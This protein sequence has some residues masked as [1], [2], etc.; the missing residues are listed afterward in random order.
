MPYEH[1]QSL[2]AIHLLGTEVDDL[3]QLSEIHTLKTL[4]LGKHTVDLSPLSNLS[5]LETIGLCG[6]GVTDVAPLAKLPQLQTLD[7]S[8]TDVR[9]LTPLLELKRLSWLNL[10][11]TSVTDDSVTQLRRAIPECWILS[12]HGVGNLREFERQ[13]KMRSSSSVPQL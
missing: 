2:T 5:N 3:S 9:D 4:S 6:A 1:F 10:S 13:S 7:L 8:G 12:A 11:N